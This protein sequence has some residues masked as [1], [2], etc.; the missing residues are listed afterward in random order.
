M[1]V[2]PAM[3]EN[4]V[5]WHKATPTEAAIAEGVTKLVAQALS[6]HLDPGRVFSVMLS[7]IASHMANAYGVEEAARVFQIF[8]DETKQYGNGT[9]H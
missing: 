3:A 4:A 9:Q 5:E 8:A 1:A 2:V 7:R 6:L